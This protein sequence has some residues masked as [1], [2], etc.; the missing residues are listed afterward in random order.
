MQMLPGIM[1]RG[2]FMVLFE[3]VIALLLA[4]A[5]LAAWSRYIGVPYPALLALAGAAAAFLPG[6]PE[7]TLEPDL[8]LA[9]FVAPV[10]LDAAFDASPRD[11]RNNWL[12]IG[13]LAVVVVGLTVAVVAVVARALVPGMPWAA[14]VAL[15]AI[16]A[17]PDASAATAVLRQLRP[18]HRLLVILEGE[19]LLNDATALLIYRVAVGA[20]AGSA[21]LSWHVLPVA[22]LTAGGGAALGWGLARLWTL[23]PA[24]RADIPVD[25]LVQFSAPSPSGSSPIGLAFP[26]SSPSS[27]M[28]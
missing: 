22:L 4:G 27:S 6:T 14:A 15:G 16:V 18:P 21:A 3:L 24:H 10:L 20:A 9:L 5:L 7:V 23:M 28:R 13:A 1:S 25:V 2:L 26:R 8:A 12:P 17:P 19:S 11:I